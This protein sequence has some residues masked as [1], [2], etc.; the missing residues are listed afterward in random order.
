MRK[1][2]VILVSLLAAALLWDAAGAAEAVRR[3]IELCLASVIPALFPF[4][5]VSSLLVSLGAGRAARILERPFRALFRC[6][7]AGAAAFLLGACGVQMGTRF[8]SAEECSIHPVYKER[9][10]KANDLCT[11][12]TG[13][14]LGHPVRSLRT[15]FARNYSKAE[16]GGMDD[17]ALEALGSGAL[18]KAVVEGGTT[19]LTNEGEH[20]IISLSRVR[21]RCEL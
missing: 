9:I 6:G 12:V 4:F 11:M 18:R 17:E 7:G 2:V 1:L 16:Y 8:L 15:N 5:V 3:G 20:K 10:L 14:R 21:K 13:K 19:V